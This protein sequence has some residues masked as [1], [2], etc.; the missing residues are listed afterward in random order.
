MV[1][2]RGLN[3]NLDNYSMFFS[4]FSVALNVIMMGGSQL[5]DTLLS[6]LRTNPPLLTFLSEGVRNAVEEGP[7]LSK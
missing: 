1:R 7:G 6:R 2:K 4:R 5:Y 3:T